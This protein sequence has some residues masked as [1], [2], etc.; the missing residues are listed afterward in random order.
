MSLYN[1]SLL[2]AL[3][4]DARPA[5]LWDTDRRRIIWAN[6]TGI[7]FWRGESLFDVLDRRF[8][9]AEPGVDRAVQL[10]KSLKDNTS[11]EEDFSFPSSGRRDML[12]CRCQLFGL[13]DGRNGVLM[14]VES[15]DQRIA[16]DAG[17][18]DAAID[19]L[20]LPVIVFNA[21]GTVVASNEL[22]REIV[23]TGVD[24]MPEPDLASL[25]GSA[26]EAG[27][28]VARATDAGLV[29]EIRSIRTGLGLRTH[30][31][32]ARHLA[33]DHGGDAGTIAIVF[34]D[35]TERRQHEL[36]LM[37]TNQRLADFV[38]AAADFTWELDRDLVWS[39]LSE[40]F[41]EASGID[42]KSVI[43]RAWPEVA[44]RFALDGSGQIQAAC[45]ARKAWRKVTEWTHEG[46][47]VSIMLSATPAVTGLSAFSGY[48]GVGTVKQ[49][50]VAESRVHASTAHDV[51]VAEPLA[52]SMAAEPVPAATGENSGG[53]T[54]EDRRTFKAIGEA[55]SQER[56]R[57]EQASA[58]EPAAG[59][60]TPGTPAADLPTESLQDAIP[61]T[62]SAHDA[63]VGFL[64]AFP[65]GIVVVRDKALLYANPQAV[66]HLGKPEE[67]ALERIEDI[68]SLL[69][70][71]GD[72]GMLDTIMMSSAGDY[73]TVVE[74]SPLA[75]GTA[76]DGDR[77]QVLQ[78]D[79][80]VIEWDGEPALQ[81][82]LSRQPAP[83]VSGPREAELE[84]ILNTATDGIVTLDA[85]GHIVTVNT[86]AQAIFGYDEVEVA[87]REFATL[88]SD[89][90]AQAVRDYVVSLADSGLASIFNDGREVVAVEKNGGEI[91]LFL[92]LGRMKSD[93]DTGASGVSFCAV[94]RDITQWK[95]AEADLKKAKE[96]AERS[97]T[98]KSEFLAK[99][100]HEL[101]TPLNAIIGFSEV[102]TTEKFGPLANDRYKGYVND[103]H[104]SGEHLLS[105]INDLLDLS[106]VEAG[107]L[108][109]SFTSV[110]L[111]DIISQSNG[112]MQPQAN[113]ERIIIRSSVAPDLPPVVADQ[114]SMRQ[115]ILNLLSNAIKFTDPGG[116]VIVSA[117]MDDAGRVQIRVK[118]T[119]IG[120]DPDE[121]QHALE[122]FRQ[123]Q[124]PG[125]VEQI[126]TGLGLPLTKALTEANKAEF[127]IEST[128]D[129]GTL[130]QIT[131]P[132]TRVLAD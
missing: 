13:P 29:S 118:D 86:S 57:D 105:L 75:L 15:P 7:G 80:A 14:T 87:G 121:L 98:Q 32:T 10:A 99:I 55:I 33:G 72:G 19:L 101:R 132:T 122:P 111:S 47:K 12:R 25:V 114:R 102:M 46:R 79:L 2:D 94:V 107:K 115:I 3:A 58:E 1:T 48:R 63:I 69:N 76:G 73:E 91:P 125:R 26:E 108:E 93:D 100:S 92:T 62:V 97:S 71:R 6:H 124:R 104:S 127:L 30:R 66:V 85:S 67:T 119:G 4:T 18:S 54:E 78:A 83:S 36:S 70:E 116:Q 51:P 120:M 117:L 106:K 65:S 126:G 21:R 39:G 22:A 112:I 61:D 103:I 128:P 90:T 130:V 60:D 82:A 23:A 123:I 38:A 34:D 68:T 27:D 45:N 129:E 40:G 59:G 31:I 35:V 9:P 113:R 17:G 110:N 84:A 20:P 24:G 16:G 88:M 77:K 109:L 28:L 52:T 74:L 95:K 43:G 96:T 41:E 44:A 89:D 37:E 131:F 81:I 50:A 49:A 56:R 42:R 11:I 64:D 53:L 8:D 5:W